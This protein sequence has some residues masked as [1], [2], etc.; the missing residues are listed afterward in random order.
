V[1]LRVTGSALA[2]PLFATIIVTEFVELFR[3]HAPL[4]ALLELGQV[5]GA[6]Q[7]APETKH[8]ARD[9]VPWPTVTTIEAIV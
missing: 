8:V 6:V 2:T 9:S 5:V 7:I 3:T 1:K 4:I